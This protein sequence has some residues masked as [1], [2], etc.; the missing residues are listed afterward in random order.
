MNG[1]VDRLDRAV[2]VLRL[3]PAD[4][5]EF[6]ELTAWIDTAFTGEL[7]LPRPTIDALG[8]PQSSTIV[9]GLADGN[10]VLLET[11]SCAIEWFGEQKIIEVVE[12]NAQLP[13]LG[14][15]LLRDRK[16]EIDYRL[17]TVALD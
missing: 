7:V 11:F 8:L 6:T 10:E 1:L 13:L 2:V 16:L 15:G 9:A 14:V 17:R 12:S 4:D 5:T 3:R